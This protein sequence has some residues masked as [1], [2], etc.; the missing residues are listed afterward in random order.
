MVFSFDDVLPCRRG[1]ESETVCVMKG[2][3][4]GAARRSAVVAGRWEQ[5]TPATVHAGVTPL[6]RSD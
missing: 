4:G 3:D 6:I 2:A 1:R 5:L